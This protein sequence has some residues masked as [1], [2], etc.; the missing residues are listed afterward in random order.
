MTAAGLHE[1]ALIVYSNQIQL[2][3]EKYQIPRY[4]VED[5]LTFLFPD[6]RS[7]RIFSLPAVIS[8]NLKGHQILLNLAN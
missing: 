5:A 4:Q 3:L 6:L 2:R 1:H 8:C 7:H